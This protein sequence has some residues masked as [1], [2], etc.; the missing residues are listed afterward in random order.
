M[1]TSVFVKEESKQMGDCPTNRR[2]ALVF[3]RLYTWIMDEP[4]LYEQIASSV[5]QKILNGNLKP[6]DRI[7]SVREMALQWNC[8]IGTIQRAYQEL[9]KQGLVVSRAGQGTRVVDKPI[10]TSIGETP[11]RRA[12]LVH[13]AESYLLEMLTAG[14]SL[15][16][17][18]DAMRE[19]MDRWRKAASISPAV[20]QKEVR[21]AGSH[22]LVITWLASHFAEIT[23][24]FTLTLSFSGS[25]GG[26]IALVE[27]TAD[28]AGSHL[29]DEESDSYN[30]SFVRRILPGRKIALVTIAHRR[31]GL[32]VP[33][34][35]P[36]QIASIE[37]LSRPGVRFANRQPGSGTRVWL[38]SHLQ[39]AGI[40][41]EAIHGYTN[42][43]S[44]HSAVALSVAE[45]EA[46]AGIGLQAA[47]LGYG[48]DFIF[49]HNDRYDLVI[50]AENMEREPIPTLV[51]WLQEENT[52]A[53]I[54][55]LG[56][57]DVSETGCVRWVG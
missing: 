27:N 22:D 43:K 38:D 34:H 20:E 5:R 40:P 10:D 28:L 15:K 35:N 51:S 56:G 3:R 57:Y 8:T 7:P 39:K 45:G 12:A 21:F 13:R 47:A 31:I 14:F 37:E 50:P 48:L 32:I 30:T 49:L 44:T 4:H 33:P 46:D 36:M 26:L 42:E 52:R 18:D 17:V 53:I 9:T 6:G 54:L 41:P 29:W 24:G 16:E 55:D 11:L 19:A 23:S 25:L 1:Q 2:L